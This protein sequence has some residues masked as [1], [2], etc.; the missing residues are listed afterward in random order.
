MGCYGE[1]GRG[2]GTQE[3]DTGN[4][5]WRGMGK[6]RSTGNGGEGVWLEIEPWFIATRK[7][8]VHDTSAGIN[9]RDAIETRKE[10]C[11]LFELRLVRQAS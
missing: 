3:R 1:E 8:D 4:G 5:D 2:K 7:R 6:G 9:S 10:S 11:H